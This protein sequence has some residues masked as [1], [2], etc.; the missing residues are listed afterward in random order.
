VSPIRELVPIV[1]E[2]G[3]SQDKG[4]GQVT[5]LTVSEYEG[6]WHGGESSTFVYDW[7]DDAHG[8]SEPEGPRE[9]D[10]MT[11]RSY[12]DANDKPLGWS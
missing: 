12:F 7:I 4:K 3:P 6:A 11:N 10:W 5:S 2:V 9:S 8:D 1:Q